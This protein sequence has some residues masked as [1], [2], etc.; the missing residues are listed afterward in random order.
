F[1]SGYQANIG[2]LSALLGPGDRAISDAANHASLIDGLR[3]AGCTRRIV[4]HLDLVAIARELATEHPGGRTFLVTES[5]FSMDGDIAPLDRYADLAE[6]HGAA[7]V[8][9]DA[10]A[11]GLYGDARGSGLA[12]SFGVAGRAIAVVSTLGK[13]V[14]IAGAFVAG[15]RVLID[16]LVNRCRSFLFTTAPPPLLLYAVEAALDRLAAEPERRQRALRLAE[17]LRAR[18]RAAGLD[19]LESQG[20]LVPVIL[21]DNRRAVATAQALADRGFDVRAARPPTVPEGTARL[22]ISVHADRTE[23]EVDAL[24]VAL[25]AV[26]ATEGS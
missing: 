23:A 13:A 24:A 12:E 4:P 7:L 8:I 1:P 16:Y 22:R 26:L 25:L 17:R 2:L 15:P 18:L 20:P 21:G 3:L 9:D 6:R 14:G 10:H 11:T 5:L 19:C